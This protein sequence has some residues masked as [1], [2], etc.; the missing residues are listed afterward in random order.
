MTLSVCPSSSFLP[1]RRKERESM[2]LSLSQLTQKFQRTL[3]NDAIFQFEIVGEIEAPKKGSLLVI[4]LQPIEISFGSPAL[5]F[6]Q[7]SKS[8]TGMSSRIFSL[9][10][11]LF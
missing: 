9:N 1:H 4:V 3:E 7:Q 2:L 11:K 8:H 6:H 10:T 5:E